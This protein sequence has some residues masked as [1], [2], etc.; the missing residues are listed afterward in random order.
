MRYW[1]LPTV[2]ALIFAVGLWWFFTSDEISCERNGGF[3]IGPDSALQRPPGEPDASPM[4][5]NGCATA[6]YS[7]EV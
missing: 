7:W 5:P 6:E 1:I 4:W 3:W 2:L